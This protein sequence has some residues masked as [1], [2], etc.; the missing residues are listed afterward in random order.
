MLGGGEVVK[1]LQM[2]CDELLSHGDKPFSESL[3]T[4]HPCTSTDIS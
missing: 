1:K 4:F 3:I 2:L